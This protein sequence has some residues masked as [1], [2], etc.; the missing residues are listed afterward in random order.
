MD[1]LHKEDSTQA[2]K[3]L[4]NGDGSFRKGPTYVFARLAP[5]DVL[6]PGQH[7]MAAG[8]L[9][10]DGRS[11]LF[12]A[13]DKQNLFGQSL[14]VTLLAKV[15][16]G[17]YWKTAFPGNAYPG[18]SF[19]A[20]ADMNGDPV[21]GFTVLSSADSLSGSHLP[22]SQSTFEQNRTSSRR[23]GEILICGRL[24]LRLGDSLAAQRSPICRQMRGFRWNG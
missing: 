8:D 9:N 5:S 23:A 21:T 3:Y 13:L 18:D 17:F 7:N 11:D 1:G 22:N 24:V 14:F 6:D 19:S 2:S 16:Q 4:G 12:V 10:G 15:S 20:L